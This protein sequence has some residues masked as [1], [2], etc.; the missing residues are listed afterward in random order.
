MYINVILTVVNMFYSHIS[1]NVYLNLYC[2]YMVE[3][4]DVLRPDMYWLCLVCHH[5]GSGCV[6]IGIRHMLFLQPG[7]GMMSF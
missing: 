2:T 5:G 7:S 6:D 4:K 1:I 3:I